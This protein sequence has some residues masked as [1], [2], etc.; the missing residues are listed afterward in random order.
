MTRLF[1]IERCEAMVRGIASLAMETGC[2]FV[3]SC[4]NEDELGT[5]LPFESVDLIIFGRDFPSDYEHVRPLLRITHQAHGIAIREILYNTD[6]RDLIDTGIIGVIHANASAE[7]YR[8]C[9]ASVRDSI[10]WIDSDFLMAMCGRTE[11]EIPT[12]TDREFDI[13]HLVQRGFRNKQIAFSLGI[14]EGTVKMYMHH[15]FT[16]LN[17]RTRTELAVLGPGTPPL[18]PG[19]LAA[20][21]QCVARSHSSS[22]R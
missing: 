2:E 4:N 16:K 5:A 15:I 9:I 11:R 21:V 1:V 12:L 20:R 17:V 7:K 19:E 14:T 18:S 6:Y 8:A 10:S 3:G 22:I 13:V